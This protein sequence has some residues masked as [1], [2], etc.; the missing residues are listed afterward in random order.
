M[1]D[2]ERTRY[3][4][5]ILKGSDNYA[6]WTLSISSVLLA[7]D[8]LDYINTS[9]TITTS[10]AKKASGKCFAH[11]IHSLSPLILSSLPNQYHDFLSPKPAGL[12]NHLKAAY[13]AAVGARQA[14]LVQELFRTT[15]EV[16]GRLQSSAYGRWRDYFGLSLG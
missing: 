9:T 4:A 3:K 8:L 15:L 6:D 14:A 11:I 2:D 10:E 1:S 7:K 16:L 13:S 5:I 12:W